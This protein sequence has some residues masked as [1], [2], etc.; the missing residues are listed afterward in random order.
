MFV[1]LVLWTHMALN[2]R[3]D[4]M[5]THFWKLTPSSVKKRSAVEVREE[6]LHNNNT[7]KYENDP[8]ITILAINK[9][10]MRL[11]NSSKNTCTLSSAMLGEHVQ[12]G[13]KYC[14]MP[15]K[16]ADCTNSFVWHSQPLTSSCIKAGRLFVN[17][18]NTNNPR[19]LPKSLLI[20]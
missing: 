3:G 7:E 19:H 14:K 5:V 16:K 6:M 15:S 9:V 2:H 1:L 4:V 12:F 20:H 10:D 17:A 18:Q 11:M 13:T 8:T